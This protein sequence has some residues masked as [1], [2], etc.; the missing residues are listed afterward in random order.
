MHIYRAGGGGGKKKNG[1][2]ANTSRIKENSNQNCLDILNFFAS[3]MCF[4]I[5]I[6]SS[7]SAFFCNVSMSKSSMKKV[8]LQTVGFL[9]I[10]VLTFISQLTLEIV[11]S[12]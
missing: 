9:Y 8:E 4:L 10:C 11:P 5:F 3:T 7:F 2:Q 12:D 1:P 6:D